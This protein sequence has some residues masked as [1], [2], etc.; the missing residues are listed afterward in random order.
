LVQADPERSLDALSR[1]AGSDE[2]IHAWALMFLV[3]LTARHRGEQEALMMARR[4]VLAAFELGLPPMLAQT[5][6]FVASALAQFGYYEPAAVLFEAV[7]AAVIGE[8]MLPDAGWQRDL[9]LAAR[10][11]VASALGPDR[12]EACRLQARGMTVAA[13]VDYAVME[14]DSIAATSAGSAGFLSS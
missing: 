1:A 4:A 13:V 6:V 10:A 12:A 3:V 9:S 11:A 5:L 14:L 7:D 8:F 2:P